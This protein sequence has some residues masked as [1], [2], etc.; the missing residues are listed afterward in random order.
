MGGVDQRPQVLRATIGAVGR[1][2][3]HAV[4]APIPP[5]REVA[6]RH[7][8][9]RG[10]ARRH[11]LV[12]A[13]DDGAKGPGL[14]QRAD[15]QLE[16]HG[17][18]PGPSFPVGTLPGVAVIDHL[19]RTEGVL[20]LKGG[21]RIGHIDLAVDAELVARARAR[22][23]IVEREPSVVVRL[24]RA[25][26]AARQQFDPAGGWRPQSEGRPAR[27]FEAGPEARP[28]AHRASANTVTE[29]AGALQ[30]APAR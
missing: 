12:E 5:P 16:Q 8:L 19:A 4:V 7:Q 15:V 3:Q 26:S 9:D 10:D 28:G 6:D 13:F 27:R 30:D 17:F 2:P 18:V 24:H 29:R 23:W 1:E 11:D 22:R 14:R 20:R 21:R 25:R